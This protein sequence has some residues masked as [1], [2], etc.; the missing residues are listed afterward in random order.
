M[1]RLSN[2]VVAPYFGASI[3]SVGLRCIMMP[4]TKSYDIV[5]E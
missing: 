4:L 5:T 2:R 1:W 3:T